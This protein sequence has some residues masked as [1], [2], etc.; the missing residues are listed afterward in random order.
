MS[1]KI[2]VKRLKGVS[3]RFLSLFLTAVLV[4][5]LIPM[6]AIP[7]MAYATISGNLESLGIGLSETGSGTWETSA[8]NALITGK[9]T[10]TSMLGCNES[11]NG[12]LTITNNKTNDAVLSFSYSPTVNGG[13]VSIDGADVKAAGTYSKVLASNESIKIVITSAKGAKTTSVTISGI[14]LVVNATITT[15]FVPAENGTITVD[16]ETISEDYTNTQAST[17][18]YVL[19]AIPAEG[20]KL[21]GWHGSVEGYFSPNQS[22]SKRFDVNQ[23]VT[24][25]FVPENQSVY[26]TNGEYYTEFEDAISAASVG[27]KR[28]VT[29]IS[30]GILPTGDHEIPSGITLLIPFD[31]AHTVSTN[32]PGMTS[33]T[34]PSSYKTLTMEN[35]SNLIVNGVLNVNGKHTA[36]GGS[37]GSSFGPTGKLGYVH[38]QDGSH[39]SVENGGSLFAY[40]YI[41][42]SGTVEAKAGSSIFELMQVGDFRGGNA[43]LALAGNRY[44]VFPFT[45]YYV[46]NIETSLTLHSGA[47]ESAVFSV[48]AGGGTQSAIIPFIGSNAMFRLANGSSLTKT[49][50]PNRD[51]LQIDVNGDAEISSLALTVA[52]Q[53]INSKDY[54]LPITN[55]IS[56]NINSGNTSIGQDIALLAGA[57]V[58]VLDG[59]TLTV[60]NG[61]NAYIYDSVEWNAGSYIN[62]PGGKHFRSI[63]FSPTKSFSR[64]E[65][66]DAILDINGTVIVEGELYTTESGASIVSTAGTGKV[67]LASKAGTQTYTYQALQSGN[68]IS[69]YPQIPIVAAR[70]LNGDGSFTETAGSAAGSEFAWSVPNAKWMAPAT[71]FTI[72]F[73]A[74]GGEGTMEPQTLTSGETAT[75]NANTFR[76][77]GYEFKGWNTAADGSGMPIPDQYSGEIPAAQ[78]VTLYAQWEK[79]PDVKHTVTFDANG[80]EGEMEPQELVENSE[81]TLN[82]ATFTRTGHTFKGWNTEADGSGT[83]YGDGGQITL[84]KDVTLYAQWEAN[85]YTI[86]FKN[87]DGTVLASTEVA[88]GTV[89]EYE[90]D[91]PAKAATAQYTYIFDGWDPELKAV[92]GKATYTA[93]YKAELNKY[94]VT[95]KNDDGSVLETDE[96]V[97]YGTTPIY[98]GE[99]PIKAADAQYTYAFKG[100]DKEVAE[101]TGDATYIATYD[102]TPNK[103]TVTWINDDGTVLETD[104]DVEYGTV[105]SYDGQT[106]TKAKDAQY[107]YTFA[108]WDPEVSAVTGDVTYK[109]VFYGELNKYTVTWKNDNGEVLET[110]KNVSYGTMP[111]YD[112]DTPSKANDIGHTYT[113]A[114]WT[115]NIASVTGDTEYTAQFTSDSRHYTIKWVNDDDEN[116]PLKSVENVAY[117]EIPEYKDEEHQEDPTKDAT[118]QFTFEFDHWSEPVIDDE[119][120]TIT[121]T[122]VYRNNLRSYTITWA[123]D[124][125]TVIKTES[126][127]YGAAPAYSGG[128]PTKEQDE[129]YS[130][131]FDGWNPEI[132]SVTSDATYTATYKAT[133]RTYTI[134]WLNADGSVLETDND[135]AYDATPSYDGETPT[136]EGDAQYSY[137]FAGWSPEIS[138]VTGDATYKA[139]YTEKVNTYTV[140]WKNE[141]GSVLETDKNVSYGTMP[142]YDGKE[143]AKAA[144]AQYTYVFDGWTPIVGAVTGDAEYTAKFSE[145]VNA[146]TVTWKNEDGFVLETDENV[147]YGTMPSYDGDMPVKEADD[148]HTYTFDAWTPELTEVTGD[149][150]YTATFKSAKN[151]WFNDGNGRQYF[152]DDKFLKG[153]NKVD[154]DWYYFDEETGYAATGMT[155][156]PRPGSQVG[157]YG[158]N[159]NDIQYHPEYVEQGY[160]AN[161]FFLF[162]EDGTFRSDYTGIYALDDGTEC[163]VANGEQSWHGCLVTDGEDYYYVSSG[164]KL[165]RSNTYWIGDTN[166][167][168]PKGYYTFGD[169]AKIMKLTGFN[170]I[171]GVTY[172]YNDGWAREYAGLIKIGDDYYYVNSKFEMVA[173]QDYYVTK[174]NDLM[175]AGVYTFDADGKM[176]INTGVKNGLIEEDGVLAY[177]VDGVRT[178]AGVIQVDGAYYYIKS[179]GTAVR[180]VDKYAVGAD[181]TNGLVP[182]G[183][184]AFD[185]NG[186]MVI[187]KPKNGLVDEGGQLYYYVDGAKTHAGLIQNDGAYYYIK[188]NCTA[189]RGCSYYIGANNTNG[190]MPAGTYTFDADGKM[191]S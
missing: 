41:Y 54:V 153:W 51:Y 174:T 73:D 80:G 30:D 53:S 127:D 176:V 177:Y 70:L 118:D 11:S 65:P 48:S 74:N 150:T 130:Y 139:A 43:T 85:K 116:T 146:Y 52:G 31:D 21:M 12:T 34:P 186:K 125:G 10:G 104:V 47:T 79:L 63:V 84:T 9:V 172:Y 15:T 148:Q 78:D 187:E 99:M 72:T 91:I 173:S 103:Y 20:Y 3:K 39:I 121:Y 119:S 171:D 159:A 59:A 82:S 114:G 189:V 28:V 160:E 142:T 138:K 165:H 14:S 156:V 126:L 162:D 19:N 122:A 184:Y 170:E 120:S 13:S 8:A 49:Y 149:A 168:L 86:T 46:Q 135:V 76:R 181:M 167:L 143:P 129:Q 92:T 71:T 106:P 132:A 83:A 123:N 50:L 133:T 101:V 58:C 164:G 188:S 22:L 97:S 77:E 24:A 112:G 191:I 87:D 124:D 66:E 88:Y 105:P 134:T 145:S 115:P 37:A 89:P 64:T 17:I 40:G 136:K 102:T 140:T 183:T 117:D 108:G 158:P 166:D 42:G 96:N 35:G 5:T 128:T 7:E 161:S 27:K 60:P 144:T 32:N 157:D 109:A 68:T 169:D 36:S 69:S 93:K 4:F 29:L 23:T 175:E 182:A 163:W 98:D 1:R 25:V 90:G 38:M 178:H 57:E 2:Y 179:N 131:E 67:S 16:G 62:V 111:T 152:Q 155:W 55:N 45:Q 151:G 18:D 154:G 44:K 26:E 95:W 110:D 141:D 56:I 180:G 107:T 100:W 6:A 61:S 94:T 75:L 137:V 185:A 81:G 190:L 33:Y 147:P 113:F